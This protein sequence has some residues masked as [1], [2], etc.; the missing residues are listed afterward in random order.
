MRK[1]TN[2]SGGGHDSDDILS[3]IWKLIVVKVILVVVAS[4]RLYSSEF[5]YPPLSRNEYPSPIQSVRYV[6]VQ[7]CVRCVSL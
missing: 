6:Q 5:E 2:F 3:V 4:R 7:Q 1:K